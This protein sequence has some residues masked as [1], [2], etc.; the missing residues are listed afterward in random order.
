MGKSASYRVFVKGLDHNHFPDLTGQDGGD[1]WHL[2]HGGFRV[3]ETASEKD[4]ITFQGDLYGG[5][6]GSEIGHIASISPPINV[7]VDG[8]ADL[9]G[10]NVLTRWNHAFSSR[11]D[12]T[13]QVYFDR[14]ERDGPESREDRDTV[15][16]DFQHHL[17]L[18]AHHDFIWG[19]DYRHTS[20]HTVGTIDQAWIPASQALYRLGTFVQDEI[21]LKPDRVWL[22]L[23]TKL[24]KNY[25]SGFEAQPSVRVAWAPKKRDTFWV[26]VSRA[27]R[28][29]ARRETDADINIAVSPGPGGIPLILLDQG[30]PNQ[31]AQH[32]IAYEAGYRAQPTGRLSVDLA[33]FF[34]T[35][36]DLAT[37]EPG[38]M[39]FVSNPPPA[40]WVS[41]VMPANK[42]YGTTQGIEVFGTWKPAHRW[43]LSPGYGLLQM[44]LHTD[45]SSLDTSSVP[46]TEGS[47]PRHQAQLRSQVDL[48]RGFAWDAS[49]YFVDR[50]PAQ[51]VRSY[52]RLD[53]QLTRRLGERVALSLVGQNLYQDHH[54]ESNN[55]VSSVNPSEVKRS[56][57]AKLVWGF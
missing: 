55:A 15:D 16:F 1:G 50:L 5:S 57:Y 48:P 34:N 11:S 25:L 6:E 38:A 43:K 19:V 31:Q 52:T 26:A 10:G 7:N 29:P 2:V 20:D 37:S 30:N 17:A 27:A 24:E 12:T 9:A 46:N 41:P 49:A 53:T 4:S 14:F 56:A 44:H 45:A 28:A 18:G 51:Q 13:L 39:Y 42:M 33:A 22:T 21:T 40:H 54:V 23:G 3:D 8:S 35:Y 36:S 47:S 32:V